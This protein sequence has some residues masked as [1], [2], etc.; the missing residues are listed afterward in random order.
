[1]AYRALNKINVP[2]KFSIPIIDE[3]LD[4]LSGATIFTKLVLKSGYDQIRMKVEGIP[5]T[6]FQTHE[7]NFEFVVMTDA[8]WP[9]QCTIHL[10]GSNE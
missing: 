1:M 4:E 7:G 5:K 9:Y 10:P 2:D 3:L 8:I 6:A